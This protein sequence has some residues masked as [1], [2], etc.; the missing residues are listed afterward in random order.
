VKDIR[1]TSAEV[2]YDF[3]TMIRKPFV[4]VKYTIDNTTIS[5]EKKADNEEEDTKVLHMRNL[6]PN[7]NYNVE[8]RKKLKKISTF[9]IV[10]TYFFSFSFVEK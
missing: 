9:C 5:R 1:E 8:V 10:F 3:K 4:F 6:Q 2:D 7:T